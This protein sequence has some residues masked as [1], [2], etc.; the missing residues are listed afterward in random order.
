MTK[1]V[2][3]FSIAVAALGGQGGGVLAQWIVDVA[4][5]NGYMAQYTSVPGVAQ[6]TGATIYYIELFPESAAAE[7]GQLPVMA[8]MPAPG[9]VDVVIAAEL[10]EAGRAVAR[11]FVSPTLTTLIA[12][13]HRVYSISE[14]E[15]MGDGRADEKT[16]RDAIARAS[17]RLVMFDMNAAAEDTG[18]VI[19]AVLY[20]ALAGSNALPFSREQYEAVIHATGKAVETNLKGFALGYDG[21]QGSITAKPATTIDVA[22]ADALATRIHTFPQGVQKTMRLGVAR[23]VDYQ[24]MAYAHTYLDRLEQVRDV[25]NTQ[26][27][28]NRLL[29]ET[30]RYLA[31]WMSFEDVLRVA[32]LKTRSG[33]HGKIGQEVRAQAGQPYYVVEYFHPRWE[34]FCDSLPAWAGR[35][36]VASK[37]AQKIFGPLFARGRN[38]HT[39]KL[40]GF[41]PLYILARL[42]RWRRGTLR[43][44]KEDTAIEAW[45]QL[46][47][48][49]AAQDYALAAEIAQC[50]RMIKGYG[51]THARGME[52]FTR[53]IELARQWVGHEQAA[54]RVA[55]LREAALK[56]EDG[57][58]FDAELKKVA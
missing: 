16:V 46:M 17:K 9:D 41:L 27:P 20:G 12:S 3:P 45:L 51:D 6:R 29:H 54:A 28:E 8:L 42:G 2:R 56:D 21:A 44:Q 43:F 5:A 1:Q 37:T 33:R 40:S 26:D 57:V 39:A 36:L 4:E 19:S 48:S 22:P 47:K 52:R 30:A 49:I 55:A 11:R 15:I 25:A 13:D 10:L 50:P 24:D 31:L 23:L 7:K 34:E 53:I 32:D 18:S 35:R 38:L 58:A 14:K